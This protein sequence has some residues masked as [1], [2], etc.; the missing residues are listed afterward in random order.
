M[1]RRRRRRA[2]LS[3]R[4]CGAELRGKE[5]AYCG[6]CYSVWTGN[7]EWRWPPAVQISNEKGRK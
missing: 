4:A 7:P 1:P 3:C 5:K 6:Y 2:K